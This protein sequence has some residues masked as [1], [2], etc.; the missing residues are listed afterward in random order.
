[1]LLFADMIA[2][3][4]GRAELEYTMPGGGERRTGSITTSPIIED[5]VVTGAVGIMRDI[6]GERR[7][8]EQLVQREKLAAIGQLVSG[9]A[10]ELNNPLAGI[11]AFAQLLH[12]ASPM[13]EDQRDAVETIHREARRA[14]KIVSNL[15]FFA[16]QR[17]PE[18]GCTDL[19]QVDARHARDAPLRAA[20]AAGGGRS[21]SS[22]TR[23]LPRGPTAS[24][25]SR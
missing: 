12:A 23:S 10:H 1:M 16:R 14:A 18:R 6:T 9:V 19:N 13:A 17:D 4:R 3:K 22:T 7:L 5:G 15:L 8:T 20:H 24:S 11:M 2:G 25:F 21:P